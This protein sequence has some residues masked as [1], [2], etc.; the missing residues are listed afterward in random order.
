MH[1]ALAL[2]LRNAL[3]AVSTGFKLQVRVHI[4]AMDLEDELRVTAGG[5]FVFIDD[6]QFP[7]LAFAVALVHIVEVAGE[8]GGFVAARSGAD[9][10]DDVPLIFR[11]FRDEHDFDLL[12]HHFFTAAEFFEF[13]LG[14][15]PHLRVGVFAHGLGALQIVEQVL[16][17]QVGVCDGPQLTV[18]FVDFGKLTGIGDYLRVRELFL[19]VL[20]TMKDGG[21]L[22]EQRLVVLN[23]WY[24]GA[25]I[26]RVRE[27]S[28]VRAAP[29]A[30]GQRALCA[31]YKIGSAAGSRFGRSL[32]EAAYAG[33]LPL[34]L[35]SGAQISA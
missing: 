30:T 24:R 3:Y 33:D 13:H 2:R 31:R 23:C 27:C 15:F 26:N 8:D 21:E 14:H 32:L 20:E 19:E 7:A 6:F 1:P 22:V 9:L 16:V 4:I 34:H 28:G 5:A 18:L 35:R 17:L 12:V 25:K 10:H 11:V 29:R